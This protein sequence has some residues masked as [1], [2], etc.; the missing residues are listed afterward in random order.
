MR[1]SHFDET[2]AGGFLEKGK[3][4][5]NV[6]LSVQQ[7]ERFSFCTAA[8]TKE[9]SIGGGSHDRLGLSGIMLKV[10]P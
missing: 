1:G 3:L 6:F 10:W 8:L 5:Y 7:T 2:P 9:I 4:F